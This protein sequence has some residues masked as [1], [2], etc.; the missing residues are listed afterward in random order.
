MAMGD[1]QFGHVLRTV[2][3][4]LPFALIILRWLT[5]WILD[6]ALGQFYH[7]PQGTQVREGQYLKNRKYIKEKA[8]GNY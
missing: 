2:F 1:Y 8:P 6:T 4:K 3:A 5:F 7:D